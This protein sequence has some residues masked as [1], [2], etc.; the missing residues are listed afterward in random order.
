MGGKEITTTNMV[1]PPKS[2]STDIQKA[3][4]AVLQF[5][6][7]SD[8]IALFADVVV[9]PQNLMADGLYLGNMQ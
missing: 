5:V 9:T 7:I 1:L 4:T 3:K 8:R 2:K 6:A